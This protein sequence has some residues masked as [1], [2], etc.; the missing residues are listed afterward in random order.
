MLSPLALQEVPAQV[1]SGLKSLSQFLPQHLTNT[2]SNFEL[3][4]QAKLKPAQAFCNLLDRLIRANEAGQNAGKILVDPIE[5][6]K[7][8]DDWTRFID[9]KAI[10]MREIP[11]GGA[12]AQK[13][14]SEDVVQLL[15]MGDYGEEFDMDIKSEYVS[16]ASGGD[17]TFNNDSEFIEHQN[18]TETNNDNNDSND[19]NELNDNI[20]FSKSEVVVLKWA[21]YLSALPWRFPHVPARLFLLCMS[22]LLTASLREISMNGGEGFGAWWVVRCWIDEWMGW[23]AEMGGFLAM[24]VEGEPARHDTSTQQ[25]QEQKQQEPQEKDQNQVGSGNGIGSGNPISNAINNGK[26]SSSSADIRRDN[27]GEDLVLEGDGLRDRAST[28]N[29]LTCQGSTKLVFPGQGG[30]RNSGES[31]KKIGGTPGDVNDGDKNNNKDKE[32]EFITDAVTAEEEDGVGAVAELDTGT[33]GNTKPMELGQMPTT[34]ST[35]ST[36]DT[37]NEKLNQTKEEEDDDNNKEG[38]APKDDGEQDDGSDELRSGGG[39]DQV[40]GKSQ[41]LMPPEDRISSS[42]PPSSS[43]RFADENVLDASAVPDI[44]SFTPADLDDVVL[45]GHE[46]EEE[47]DGNETNKSA[48]TKKMVPSTVDP[49]NDR[50][51]SNNRSQN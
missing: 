24:K 16:K 40:Q 30:R 35:N 45:S 8:R 36:I 15:S 3:M 21:Q 27:F 34:T 41:K 7:M 44:S 31:G 6:R 5:T 42:S 1:I 49:D 46:A 26:N 32:Y 33:G 17:S 14:L 23:S 47:E 43:S 51:N 48:I 29:L 11:C 50:K 18:A 9:P 38:Y 2:L 12:D 4:L 22:G 10:V 25:Q 20:A 28:E 37:D 13:I 39:S 19:G